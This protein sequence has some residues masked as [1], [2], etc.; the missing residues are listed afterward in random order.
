MTTTTLVLAIL[1]S[2]FLWALAGFGAYVLAQAFLTWHVVRF[3]VG[4]FIL[5][6]MWFVVCDQFEEMQV[7]AR[8]RR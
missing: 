4:V 5:A 6:G 1:G 7:R 8:G 3:A 2:L